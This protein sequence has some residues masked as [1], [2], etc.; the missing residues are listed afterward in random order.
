[1]QLSREVAQKVLQT[2]DAGLVKGLGQPI[3]GQMCVEAAVNYALGLPHGDE[4]QCV[5]SAVRAFKI[6]LNDS[7]WPSDKDRTEGMRKLAIAQLGSDTIDQNEFSIY[8]VVET[9]KRILPIA[10]RAAA[11]LIPA[12]KDAL[13]GAAVVCEAV[14]DLAS[15]RVAASAGKDIAYAA[16]AA[17]AAYAAYAASSKKRLEVLRLCA[18][19]GLEAMIA[20]KSPGCEWLDLCEAA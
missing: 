12:H 19:I 3:P 1:M 6:R 8:V 11:S 18:Q 10:F 16:Y 14:V 15:A 20:L 7:A 5:G 17:S 13:E 9:V 2:V 4:P